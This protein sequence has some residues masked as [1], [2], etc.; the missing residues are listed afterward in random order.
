MKIY[1]KIQNIFFQNLDFS[2]IKENR[3]NGCDIISN[4]LTQVFCLIKIYH[5]IQNIFF[6][7]LIFL[8]LK[9]IEKMAEI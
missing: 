1:H 2:H 5:E 9:K 7:I 4:I 6:K 8:I 3:K